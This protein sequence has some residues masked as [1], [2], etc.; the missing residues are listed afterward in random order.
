MTNSTGQIT[1]P[2]DLVLKTFNVF[3]IDPESKIIAIFDNLSDYR[4][5][6]FKKNLT[7]NTTI[8]E[9]LVATSECVK[10]K[11]E[12]QSYE[13]IAGKFG[14]QGSYS[15]YSGSLQA[16]ISTSSSHKSTNYSACYY[17]TVNMGAA[18]LSQVNM[19]Q[20]D[21]FSEEFQTSIQ[22]ITSISLAKAHIDKYG[23]HVLTGVSLGGACSI[24]IVANT[25]TYADKAS[26]SAKVTGSYD[27]VSGS[28][29]GAASA[30]FE[31]NQS[32]SAY[33][34]EQTAEFYGGNPSLAPNLKQSSDISTWQASCSPSTP[35]GIQ[36]SMD[37]AAVAKALKLTTAA[38]YLE[39]YVNLFILK[40]SLENPTFFTKEEP[41]AQFTTVEA[42]ATVETENP[43]Q[44]K[45]YKIIGGGAAVTNHTDANSFL[46]GC[47]PQTSELAG[48][49]LGIN[50]WIAT[51]HDCMTA[52]NTNNHLVSYAVAV[53]DPGNYLEVFVSEASGNITTHGP[54]SA[55]NPAWPCTNKLVLTGGGAQTVVN[56]GYPKF[57]VQ[58]GPLQVSGAWNCW[59]AGVCDYIRFA[60]NVE[61]HGY[62]I[63]IS[64]SAL[65]ITNQVIP[66]EASSPTSH[67]NQQG[68]WEG[69]NII[70]GGVTLGPVT[71][72]D[73][74]LIRQNYPKNPTTWQEFNSDLDGNVSPCQATAY[75]IG[76]TVSINDI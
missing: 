23:T 2:R 40:Y 35:Y 9:P 74:N 47:Y 31:L 3:E 16:A 64:S 69:Q 46:T 70:G 33:N 49:L 76:L 37:M 55:N 15:F 20:L 21:Y 18:H 36:N 13:S 38:Q 54:D 43:E 67:G 42:T 28:I 73:G 1:D 53:Y 24:N 72:S 30:A 57:L 27:S 51:S 7:K 44:A 25:D 50:G 75:A 48:G 14:L 29:S 17:G 5:E 6:S 45:F 68:T 62:A 59:H 71:Q 63:G 41:V 61:L 8:A 26:I 66:N 10:T 56:G 32:G 39:D 4:S 60:T 22:N 58:N 34:L 65:T 11:S 19:P 52:A 12:R